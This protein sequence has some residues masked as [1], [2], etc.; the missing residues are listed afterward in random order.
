MRGGRIIFVSFDCLDQINHSSFEISFFS[1]PS[2]HLLIPIFSKFP[3]FLLLNFESNF[4]S[5][6]FSF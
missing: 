4:K 1:F 3:D 2:I 6:F 5:L